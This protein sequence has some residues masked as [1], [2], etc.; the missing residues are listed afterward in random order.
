MPNQPLTTLLQSAEALNVADRS[1]LTEL[2]EGFLATRQTPATFTP[3]EQAHI[4]SLDKAPF[5]PAEAEEV[6]ALF[7]RRG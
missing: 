1:R 6:A 4:Q 7:A 3:E 5:D 2:V